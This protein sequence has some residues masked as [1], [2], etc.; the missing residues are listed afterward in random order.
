LLVTSNWR[1]YCV[2]YSKPLSVTTIES[3][4]RPAVTPS[5]DGV[6]S[7]CVLVLS[8]YQAQLASVGNCTTRF[9][10]VTYQPAVA[11]LRQCLLAY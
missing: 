11:H 8:G 2:R 3:P 1:G 10:I 4:I 5:I 7:L 9:F 6:L